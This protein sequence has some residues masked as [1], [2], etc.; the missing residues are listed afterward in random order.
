MLVLT[1][2]QDELIRIG[3]DIVIKVVRIKGG[4]KT[5]VYLL[6]TL[7]HLILCHF[8]GQSPN[9]YKEIRLKSFPFEY[10]LLAM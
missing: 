8:E 10:W 3:K 4:L 7:I 1:R 6:N 5:G 9:P 2:R